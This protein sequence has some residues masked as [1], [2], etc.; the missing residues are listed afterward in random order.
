MLRDQSVFMA[1]AAGIEPAVPVLET[2]GL[3]LTD[4]PNRDFLTT[5]TPRPRGYDFTSLWGS[6]L[7]QM[8]QNFLNSSRSVFFFLFFL[9]E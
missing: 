5:Q 4:A 6:C 9:Y 2:G 8:R 3:P 7:W 1:G